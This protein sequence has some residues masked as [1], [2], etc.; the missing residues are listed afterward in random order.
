M[1]TLALQI[2]AAWVAAG[3]A[4]GLVA[5]PA[6]KARRRAQT[7]RAGHETRLPKDSSQ[8]TTNER[9]RYAS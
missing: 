7:K 6:L 8:S 9:K 3:L 1:T 4:L 2:L 5:G